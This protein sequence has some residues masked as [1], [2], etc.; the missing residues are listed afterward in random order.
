MKRTYRECRI[1]M[2]VMAMK[3]ELEDDDDEQEE[4]VGS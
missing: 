1:V 2:K 3:K 4:N